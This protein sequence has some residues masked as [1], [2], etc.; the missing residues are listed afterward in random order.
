MNWLKKLTL[1]KLLILVLQSKKLTQKLAALKK[2]VTDHNYRN[3]YIIIQEFNKL[4]PEKFAARLKQAN[5][6]TKVD[7]DDSVE[8]TDFDDKLKNLN[9]K[10]TSN[11]TSI[12]VCQWFGYQNFIAVSK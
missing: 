2:I 5:V 3:K 12:Q 4:T 6:A 10:V 8:K 11:K 1:F 9:K 7:I